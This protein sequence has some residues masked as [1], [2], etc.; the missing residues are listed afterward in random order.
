MD[1]SMVIVLKLMTELALTLMCLNTHLTPNDHA[2][3]LLERRAAVGA[4]AGHTLHAHA[5]YAH[6]TYVSKLQV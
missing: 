5:T 3:D 4:N 6:A 2:S 1:D